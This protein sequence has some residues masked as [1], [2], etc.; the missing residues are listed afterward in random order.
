[1][2]KPL[3]VVPAVIAALLALSGCAAGDQ[4]E[5]TED[6]RNTV[7]NYSAAILNKYNANFKSSLQNFSD[8]SL[9]NLMAEEARKKMREEERQR[10][11]EEAKKA[12]ADQEG[13]EDGEG[14]E[15]G[16]PGEKPAPSLLDAS[17]QEITSLSE[18]LGTEGFDISYEGYD[19]LDTY[20]EA[21]E[22][23]AGAFGISAA[24]GDKLLV[25]HFQITNASEETAECSI[26]DTNTTFRVKL[27]G[28]NHSVL[29]TLLLDDFAT[30]EETLEPGTGA[31]TVLIAEISEEKAESLNS[32]VLI[33]KG[34][35]L[36]EM[37][38]MDNTGSGAALP[39]EPSGAVETEEAGN[40]E[41]EAG[42]EVPE[43]AAGGEEEA[44][45]EEPEEA[46]LPEEGQET[47]NP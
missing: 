12:R 24:A 4:L 42:E 31:A 19:L 25:M 7:V 35:P 22:T 43:E 47:E 34:S 41:E 9:A 36:R 11:K 16:E 37:I 40:P 2:K 18:A 8:E 6:Q 38:L 28:E 15:G 46:P 10:Q 44:G 26:L 13:G 23:D 20:P 33:L 17:A 14:G 21:S 3:A 5:L 1:M 29:S 30:F 32:L 39:Q 45:G 27:N